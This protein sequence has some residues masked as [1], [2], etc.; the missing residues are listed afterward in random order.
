MHVTQLRKWNTHRRGG[1]DGSLVFTLCWEKSS[2]H[3]EAILPLGFLVTPPMQMYYSFAK[4]NVFWWC[5]FFRAKRTSSEKKKKHLLM[6]LTV[7]QQ[8]SNSHPWSTAL[9]CVLRYEKRHFS[10]GV[11]SLNTSRTNHNKVSSSWQLELDILNRSGE[12]GSIFFLLSQTFPWKG[13]GKNWFKLP[14]Y[15]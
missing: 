2:L 7:Y 11:T 6:F 8:T 4:W 1:V 3:A 5:P 10:R 9:E 12:R 14:S 13:R 15:Y